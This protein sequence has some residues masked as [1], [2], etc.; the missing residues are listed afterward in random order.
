MEEAITQFLT[1]YGPLA[2]FGLIMLSGVGLALGEDIIVIPAGMLIATEHLP[3]WQTTLAAYL[4]VVLADILWFFICFR[5]GT[6]LLHRRW[7]KKLV[8]P[9]RL[10][11]AKH[12]I[13]QRGAWMIVVTRFIPASRTT[14]ITMAGMLHM[15]PWKFS[16]AVASCALIST[17]LQLGIGYLIASG[18]GSKNIAHMI[19]AIVGVIVLFFALTI[20]Y[21]WWQAQR[22]KKERAPRARVG[23]LK[24]FRPK[25]PKTTVEALRK[26]NTKTTSL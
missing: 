23:W 19:M 26:A 1:D 17:P 25:R 24:R 20:I 5:Y 12:Q 7:F 15:S 8:H 9:R 2:V 13:E 6:P 16:L 4:G 14:A 10:L 18:I 22:A 3:M 11:Q 21:K